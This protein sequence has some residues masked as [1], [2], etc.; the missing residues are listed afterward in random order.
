MQVAGEIVIG[1]RE[2]DSVEK[3][4]HHPVLTPDDSERSM[5]V[6]HC[7]NQ[8]IRSGVWPESRY[9]E[10]SLRGDRGNHEIIY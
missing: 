9:W 5:A 7:A 10:C 6:R 1:A 2:P 8:I 3:D 4:V